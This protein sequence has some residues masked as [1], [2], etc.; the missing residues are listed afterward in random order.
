MRNNQ[1]L[2]IELLDEEGI[3]LIS[4]KNILLQAEGDIRMMSRGAGILME[5]DSKIL[6]RQRTAKVEVTDAINISGGKI[7]MN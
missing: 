1:G 7:Y 3:R 2:S 6:L 5:A 4:D